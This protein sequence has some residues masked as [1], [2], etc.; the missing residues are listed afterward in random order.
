MRNMMHEDGDGHGRASG[1]HLFDETKA[2]Y[3]FTR[4][5]H[6]R[7]HCAVFVHVEH[8]AR[9][10]GVCPRNVFVCIIPVWSACVLCC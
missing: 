6:A 1:V 4:A 9:M 10:S 2:V 7:V 8:A 3:I 5:L